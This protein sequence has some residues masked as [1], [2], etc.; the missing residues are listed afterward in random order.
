MPEIEH[1]SATPVYRQVADAIRADIEEGRLRPLYPLPS[2]KHLQQEFGISRDSARRAIA[3]LTS[4]GLVHTVPNKGTFVKARE[5][6]VV[7]CEPGLRI[8]AREASDM[9]RKTMELPAG[10]WVLVIERHGAD[11]QVLPAGS[12]EVRVER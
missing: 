2:E 9:E 7:Q 12:A 10:E 3:H 5:A 4:L 1:R 8:L 6:V 11:V